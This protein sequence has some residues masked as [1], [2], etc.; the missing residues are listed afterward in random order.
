MVADGYVTLPLAADMARD[1]PALG[2]LNVMPLLRSATGAKVAQA[3]YA[4]AAAG[5]H[6]KTCLR[7]IDAAAAAALLAAAAESLDEAPTTLHY[8]FWDEPSE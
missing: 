4:F 8:P 7:D 3:R 5:L 6:G 1:D 2:S